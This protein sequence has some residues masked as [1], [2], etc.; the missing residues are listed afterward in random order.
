MASNERRILI[1]EDDP[2]T[3]KFL[4]NWLEEAVAASNP[5]VSLRITNVVKCH[6]DEFQ[7]WFDHVYLKG[8]T[9]EKFFHILILDVMFKAKDGVKQTE[10]GFDLYQW[11]RERGIN[12]DFDQ[13]VVISNGHEAAS[14]FA[15]FQS[16]VRVIS[17]S[18]GRFVE[19]FKRLL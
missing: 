11:L 12:D 16:E 4:R 17:K 19:L 5:P 8:R 14:L 2:S 15:P 7:D 1:V 6:L 3:P 10:G 9:P 13:V 18:H